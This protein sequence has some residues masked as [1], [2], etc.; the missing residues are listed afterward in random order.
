MSYDY[1]TERP[2]IFTEDG[3]KTLQKITDNVDRLLKLAGA[4]RASEAWANC[5]G[6]S[7][8]FTACLDYLV[9]TGR[10][11]EVTAPDSVWGQHRVF[12]KVDHD[13]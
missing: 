12:V 2:Q 11:R 8:L 4:I 10:I 6:S 7:W 3:V 9:E 1:A 5:T 13:A